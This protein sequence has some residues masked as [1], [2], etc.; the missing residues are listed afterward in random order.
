M[1]IGVFT[2]SFDLDT[3]T[4]ADLIT[5][6]NGLGLPIKATTADV[7]SATG[8]VRVVL[9]PTS[10]PPPLTSDVQLLAPVLAV[11]NLPATG[12]DLLVVAEVNKV[13][14][15]RAFDVHGQIF[16]DIDETVLLTQAPQTVTLRALIKPLEPPHTL[17]NQEKGQVIASVTALAY[18]TPPL[19]LASV[20]NGVEIVLTSEALDLADPRFEVPV[21]SQPTTQRLIPWGMAPE[22]RL[23]AAT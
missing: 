10:P 23:R 11:G 20:V 12:T 9:T 16:L 7:T 2:K 5:K 8:D 17:T 3:P 1:T 15:F 22:C 13:L 6:I 19:G 4:L 18:H 14:H 21:N